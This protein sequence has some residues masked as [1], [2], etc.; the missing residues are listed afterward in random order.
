M[1]TNIDKE[2]PSSIY[3]SIGPSKGHLKITSLKNE[4]NINPQMNS[5]FNVLNNF[6]SNILSTPK[7]LQINNPNLT[8]TGRKALGDVL[9]TT[10]RKSLAL[11]VTPKLGKDLNVNTPSSQSH[12]SKIQKNQVREPSV[13]AK[14][15]N[16]AE[17]DFN[18]PIDPCSGSKYDSFADLFEDGKLS[19]LFLGKNVSF[20]PQMPTGCINSSDF[21]EDMLKDLNIVGDKQWKNHLKRLN[22]TANKSQIKSAMKVEDLLK[23]EQPSLDCMIPPILEDDF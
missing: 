10:T 4:K 23:Q 16:Y 18:A 19:D 14:T 1:S 22:K 13:N 3:A 12:V 17:V 7:V 11:G 5:D 6:K 21:K 8:K 9:N 20:I 2:N 15:E